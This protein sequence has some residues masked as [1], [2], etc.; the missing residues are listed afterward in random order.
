MCSFWEAAQWEGLNM[1]YKS[2]LGDY[3]CIFGFGNTLNQFSNI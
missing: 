2:E 1:W 3:N